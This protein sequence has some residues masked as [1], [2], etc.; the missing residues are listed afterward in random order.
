MKTVAMI[1]VLLF[2]AGCVDTRY[3]AK[4][5]CM[6]RGGTWTESDA[7]EF[8]IIKPTGKVVAVSYTAPLYCDMEGTLAR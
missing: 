6:G 8:L 5:W 1:V 3:V 7:K 2:L 4:Y